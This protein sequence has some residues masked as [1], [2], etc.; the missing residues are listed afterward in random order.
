MNSE[1]QR[2]FCTGD[3]RIQS[4]YIHNFRD[5][6]CPPS[7]KHRCNA[8]GE[9]CTYL[10]ELERAASQLGLLPP[11]Q[12]RGRGGQLMKHT[13]LIIVYSLSMFIV[14]IIRNYFSE[15]E[16]CIS[17]ERQRLTFHD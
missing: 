11:E 3:K 1:K 14:S 4:D 16:G 5:C 17:R 2:K 10:N 8:S 6:A 9:A 15:V 7:Q 12:T 13:V